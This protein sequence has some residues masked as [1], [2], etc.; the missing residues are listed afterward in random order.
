M[1]VGQDNVEVMFEIMNEIKFERD[2]SKLIEWLVSTDYFYAP[3]STRFHDSVD[4]GLFI[5]SKR[6]YDALVHMNEL[7]GGGYSKETL[8]YVGFFHDLCKVNIYKPKEVWYKDD[9]DKWQSK[10]GWVVEDNFP[11]GH[12]EKSVLLLNQYV[13]LTKEEMLAIRYHMGGFEANVAV[14]T[15]EKNTYYRAKDMTGL[16][17]LAISADNMAVAMTTYEDTGK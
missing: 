10:P 15:W 8:F 14:G 13:D 6:M 7:V 12:G 2:P 9:K 1:C 5:H 16:V 4:G 11:F 17:S 3:A